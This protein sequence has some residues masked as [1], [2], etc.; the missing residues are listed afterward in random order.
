MAYISASYKTTYSL[1]FLFGDPHLVTLDGYRYTFNGRGD[2]WLVQ[3]ADSSFSFQ[4]RMIPALDA[5]GQPVPATVFSV[6]VAQQS[7]SDTVQLELASDQ[8]VA[9]IN[10]IPVDLSVLPV[11]RF[12]NVSL[13]DN[14]GNRISVIFSSGVT[15]EATADNGFIASTFISLPSTFG[16]LVQGLLGVFNG[17]QSDDLTPQGGGQPLPLNSSLQTIHNEFGLTCKKFCYC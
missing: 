12:G 5:N 11:Q 17:D 14:G 3:T 9:L 8:L 2:F 10:G 4:G 16:G 7:N 15:I 6:L 13:V 1:G